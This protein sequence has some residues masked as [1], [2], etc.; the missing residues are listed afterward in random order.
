MSAIVASLTRHLRSTEP[1]ADPASPGRVRLSSYVVI[2]LSADEIVACSLEL[3][4]VLR[5]A[6]QGHDMVL[7]GLTARAAAS[8]PEREEAWFERWKQLL[9]SLQD[10]PLAQKV[11]LLDGRDSVGTWLDRPAQ[12]HHLG[13]EFLLHHGITCRCALRQ[14]ER[15]RVS[16]R[17]N[18]LNICGSFGIR[19]IATDLP[20]VA[21]RVARRLAHE[22]LADL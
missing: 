10:D 9:A 15:R 17:E 4:R 1:V 20:E 12:L 5:R 13:A 6:D 7:L 16:P 11:Y 22:D 2:D 8:N 3:M 21:E 18:I 19:K 14:T